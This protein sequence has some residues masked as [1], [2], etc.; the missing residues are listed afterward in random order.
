LDQARVSEFR[1]V[2]VIET[3]SSRP[4]LSRWGFVGASDDVVCEVIEMDGYSVLTTEVG[5]GE[6]SGAVTETI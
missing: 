6:A 4:V 1:E 2:N 3:E 5:D